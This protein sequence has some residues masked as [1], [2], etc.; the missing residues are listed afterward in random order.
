MDQKLV[1]ESLSVMQALKFFLLRERR[2]HQEDIDNITNDLKLLEGVELPEE[3]DL[4]VWVVID[5]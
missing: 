2:R 3:L 5:K 1:I 4:D